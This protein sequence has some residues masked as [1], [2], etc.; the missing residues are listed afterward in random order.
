[1]LL[2]PDVRLQSSGYEMTTVS[3]QL[4]NLFALGEKPYTDPSGGWWLATTEVQL[5]HD[6]AVL[7]QHREALDAPRGVV[8]GPI[9]STQVHLET[10]RPCSPKTALAKLRD[11]A[12]LLSFATMERVQVVSARYDGGLA[13]AFAC[14][15]PMLSHSPVIDPADGQL[16]R[17]FLE[18]AWLPYRAGLRKDRPDVAMEYLLMGEHPGLPAEV[19]I[20]LAFVALE[21]LKF[22]YA[23]S[24]FD[25]KGHSFLVGKRPQSFRMLTR[26][27]LRD[28]GIEQPIKRLIDLRNALVHTGLANARPGHLRRYERDVR[29][30]SIRYILRTLGHAGPFS[31]GRHHFRA[32]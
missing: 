30:L 1:M 32:P 15:P 19:R 25:R 6:R 31:I 2:N 21:S 12:A 5:G 20:T 16:L 10:A 7:R 23:L 8:A 29:A 26:R 13:Q 28:R 14:M 24:R 17:Q 22:R 4:A 3:A 27:M 18:G 9:L 11:L